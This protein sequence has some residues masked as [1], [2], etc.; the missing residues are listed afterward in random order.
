MASF[1]FLHAADIHLDSPLRGLAADPEAPAARIRDASRVA[2][3]N[4]V[5]A[6]LRH[7]VA[8]VVVA[9]DLFDGDWQ[10]WR[11]GHA[12]AGQLARLTRSGIRVVMIRGNHDA[13]SVLTRGLALPDGAALLPHDRPGTVDLPEIGAAVHGQSF[14]T[15]E[16][17]DNLALRYPAP[18]PGRVNIGL[19]HTAASGRDGHA[20]YA[21]CGI[22]Q[23]AAHGYHY[24][25]LGHVHTREVLHDAPW[26]VFPG[27]LQGRHIRE[28][29]AKGAMLVTV[30]DGAVLPPEHLVLD[31]VRWEH[32]HLDVTGAA[33]TEAVHTLL[34]GALGP[35]LDG[36]GGRLLALRVTLHGPTAAH[37]AL[38][39]DAG[40]TRGRIRAEVLA[41]S[42]PGAAWVE[43]VRLRTRPAAAPPAAADDAVQVL[44]GAIQGAS[45]EA[46]AASV[47]GYAK[48]LLDRAAG[49]R[50][51]LGEDHPAVRAAAG[52]LPAELVQRARDMLLARLGA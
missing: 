21:P 22:E 48:G 52:E 31:D 15:R 16:V 33:D 1:R 39:R 37:G 51:A 35:L 17:L 9:G 36:A 41:A 19:L 29:G 14:A 7:R 43:D 38:L 46:V 12:M 42:G 27:N 44:L 23:L 45:P 6:A 26:I 13:D 10:D 3:G 20:N 25:A 18:L 4:L 28:T 24:W 5:D 30:R 50:G 40:E 49:L 8:L 2:L 34:H 32:L 47:R 11:T